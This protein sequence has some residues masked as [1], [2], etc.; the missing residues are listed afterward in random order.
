M[1]IENNNNGTINNQTR[2]DL[3]QL[4]SSGIETGTSDIVTP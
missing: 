2:D 3:K 4:F 1:E